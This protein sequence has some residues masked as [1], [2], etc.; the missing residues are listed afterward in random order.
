MFKVDW[1]MMFSRFDVVN[2][3]FDLQYCQLTA[4]GLSGHSTTVNRGSLYI[5]H[6]NV[7]EYNDE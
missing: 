2:V 7:S 4:M 6:I 1:V 5:N 3:L